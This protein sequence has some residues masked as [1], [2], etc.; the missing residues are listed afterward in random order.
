[1]IKLGEKRIAVTGGAGF[2]GT[3]VVKSLLCRGVPR[4]Q[5]CIPRSSKYNLINEQDVI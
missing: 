2:L 3:A 1:M 4:H 5:I